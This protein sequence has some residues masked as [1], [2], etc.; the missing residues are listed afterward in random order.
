MVCAFASFLS[1]H[2][3]DRT[4]HRTSFFLIGFYTLSLVCL[5]LI[6]RFGVLEAVNP[7]S[8]TLRGLFVLSCTIAGIVGGAVSIFFWKATK[9][10]IGAWG[11]LAFALWIQCFRDGGLIHQI[12]FRWIMYIGKFAFSLIHIPS[13]RTF[14]QRVPW[15][16]SYCARYLSCTTTFSS[17]PLVSSVRPHSCLASTVIQLLI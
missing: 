14:P 4:Y 6:M 10:F 15:L 13:L 3:H 7:P 5:V 11:G 1:S 9:F 12:G 2:I 16:D 17:S 8:K